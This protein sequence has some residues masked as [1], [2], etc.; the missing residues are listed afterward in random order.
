MQLNEFFFFFL[1]EDWQRMKKN[2]IGNDL[3][4]LSDSRIPLDKASTQTNYAIDAS[5]LVV[6]RVVGRLWLC[7]IMCNSS[8]WGCKD[9]TNLGVV[10]AGMEWRLMLSTRRLGFVW[11]ERLRL[12]F[13]E[14]LV[15]KK[16]RSWIFLCTRHNKSSLNHVFVFFNSLINRKKLSNFISSCIRFFFFF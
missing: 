4:I 5:T 12:C 16:I 6:W 1:M 10:R 2:G 14:S 9:K 15:L 8:R 13:N 3:N 11:E 7:S